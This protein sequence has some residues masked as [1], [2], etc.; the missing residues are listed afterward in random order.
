MRARIIA[1]RVSH[2]EF[3]KAIEALDNGTLNPDKMI[4]GLLKLEDAQKG[5]DLL[6][7]E[8]VKSQNTSKI[9]AHR[10]LQRKNRIKLSETF[11][12]L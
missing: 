9:I 10:E 6:D 12:Q 11:L 5:F 4:T 7:K 3:S 1:S 2:G 8:P